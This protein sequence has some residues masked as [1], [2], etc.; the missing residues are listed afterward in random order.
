MQIPDFRGQNN[1]YQKPVLSAQQVLSAS[2]ATALSVKDSE[3]VSTE[4]PNKNGHFS[5]TPAG[6]ICS[7]CPP[8]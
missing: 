8:D 2:M 3:R 6:R 4:L 7:C 1:G 5:S